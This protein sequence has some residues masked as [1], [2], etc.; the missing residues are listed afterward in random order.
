MSREIAEEAELMSGENA[1]PSEEELAELL[2]NVELI[3]TDGMPLESDWHRAQIAL[4]IEII[5]W[6][7]RGRTDYYVGGNMF[8]YYSEDQAR[9]RKYR[10]PDFF[11]VA[12][13]NRE[14]RRRYWV[15]WREGGRYPDLIIELLSP[16]TAKVDRTTKKE[17][18]EKVFRTSEYF[19]YDPASQRLEGWR[20]SDSAYA[21][22]QPSEKGRLYCKELGLWLGTWT[23][24]YLGT[25]EVWLRFFDSEGNLVLTQAEAFEQR[26]QKAE[27]ELTQLKAHLAEKGIPLE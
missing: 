20:L 3:E 11:F 9:S 14:P 8:I 7:F 18:Y 2:P 5:D 25:Q 24:K 23:G 10:G 22:Q 21:E 12:G 1:L 4:L 26:A 27:A 19:C 6:L 13:V 15:V 16:K 17:L